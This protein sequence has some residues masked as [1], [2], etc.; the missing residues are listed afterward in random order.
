VSL[1]SGITDFF[2]CK[3]AF[4]YYCFSTSSNWFLQISLTTSKLNLK[5][6]TLAHCQSS[7][8]A[9]RARIGIMQVKES[10]HGGDAKINLE[11]QV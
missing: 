1:A 4:V 7:S 3:V 9:G 5:S 2:A 8:I 6:W 11:H 10:W